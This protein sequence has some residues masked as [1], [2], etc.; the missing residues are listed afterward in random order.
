MSD[1]PAGDSSEQEPGVVG[2][3]TCITGNWITRRETL[4][5]IGLPPIQD[6]WELKSL[7]TWRYFGSGAFCLQDAPTWM[8]SDIYIDILH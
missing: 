2:R 1:V 8:L 7:H 5:R 6:W 4:R 3:L